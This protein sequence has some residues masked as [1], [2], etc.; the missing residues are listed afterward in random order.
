M[1]VK[2]SVKSYQWK[3]VELDAIHRKGK[4]RTVNFYKILSN[5]NI[6]INRPEECHNKDIDSLID[7]PEEICD[8]NPQ[9]TCR[10][11]TKLVPRLKPKHEC[12]I[13]PQEVCNLKFTSPRTEKKPLKSEWCLDDSPG[14]AA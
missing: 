4:M 10:L 2:P 13:I 12:T 14:S 9:K 8:L 7:V 1:W 6:F 3:Y 11:A 5:N